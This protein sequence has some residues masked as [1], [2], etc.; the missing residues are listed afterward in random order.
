MNM[1]RNIKI[2]HILDT[3][4]RIVLFIIVLVALDR[5]LGMVLDSQYQK[6]FSGPGRYNFIKA[7]RYDCLVM[8][9]S[10]STCY[11]E[12]ILSEE[13]GKTVLNVGLD[14][15]ALIYSRCL[16]DLIIHYHV[17]PGIIIYNI[18]LFEMSKSAW[19]GNYYSM[20]EQFRPFYGKSEYIDHALQKGK[21]FEFL[22]YA[23]HTYKYND[24]PLSIIQKRIK[25][26]TA[27]KRDRSPT[28]EMSLPIDQK[29]VDDKFSDELDLDERKIMLY[30]DLIE[31]CKREDIKLVFV[32]SPIYYPDRRMTQR[33]IELECI[34][35]NL[36]RE[37]GVPFI[38]I[39]QDTHPVFKDHKLFK[40]VLHLN[41][42]GSIVFS[43]IVSI[44]MRKKGII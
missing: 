5:T 27:Y 32:E 9:S 35:R 18:D 4:S 43:K 16:L 19:N 23:L 36:A 2:E 8:G 44:E 34:I 30:R 13:L 12:E 38:S 24:L 3:M 22:K 40:D 26:G 14:G 7:N 42:G 41:D 10:T 6:I 20:I 17:K 37:S 29:T 28:D 33:D 39:T 11:Y 1:Q 15:S 31:V 25:G 21:P